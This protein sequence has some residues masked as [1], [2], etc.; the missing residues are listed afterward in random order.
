[1][2]PLIQ[3]C[4]VVATLAVVAIAVATV[5]AMAHVEKATDRFNQLAGDVRRWAVQANELTCE[6]QE[7]LA[8]FRASVAPIGR[9][10]ERF[11]VLGERTADLSAA[12]L[13]E[14]EEPLRTA[15]AVAGGIRSVTAHLLKRFSHRHVDGRSATNGGS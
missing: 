4:V 2:L 3:V 14:V 1:M 10:V 11:E 6:T 9:V 5:R 12:V 15:V 8:S 13:E 7:A